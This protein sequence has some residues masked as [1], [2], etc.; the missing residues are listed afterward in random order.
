M[1][2]AKSQGFCNPQLQRRGF[3]F[4][5]LASRVGHKFHSSP[6]FTL[7]FRGTLR[8]EESLSSRFAS[9]ER[10]LTSFREIHSRA[11]PIVHSSLCLTLSFRFHLFG[12]GSRCS[13]RRAGLQPGQT[14]LALKRL[15]P[16]KLTLAAAR[17]PCE[18]G[19]HSI[20]EPR[21]AH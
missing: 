7:S 14:E 1:M 20:A 13:S 16:L 18:A 3:L 21:R 15:Q 6:C 11:V 9:K 8:A 12:A 4:R 10:A 5:D 19:S 17:L 2:Q